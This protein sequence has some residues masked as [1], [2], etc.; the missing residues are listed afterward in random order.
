MDDM[1]DRFF[2]D[3]DSDEGEVDVEEYFEEFFMEAEDR[4]DADGLDPVHRPHIA[5]IIYAF[6]SSSL[7]V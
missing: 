1:L 3:L 7:P 4:R 6:L 5:V 2:A